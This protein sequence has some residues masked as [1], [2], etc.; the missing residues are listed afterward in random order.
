MHRAD[1]EKSLIGV[2][3]LSLKQ[4]YNVKQHSYDAESRKNVDMDHLND[5]TN[6]DG[7]H[8]SRI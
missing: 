3:G 7:T 2:S 6:Q 1:S 8:T 5:Q 4:N